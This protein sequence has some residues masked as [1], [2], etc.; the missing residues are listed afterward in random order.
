MS[1]ELKYPHLLQPLR[2][3]GTYF[4]NR[5]FSAPQG[6][7]N[8]CA[9]RHPTAET[10]AF[11]E[12][13]AMGGFASVCVGDCVVDITTGANL[14]FLLDMQDKENLPRMAMLAHAITRHGAVASAELAH[15]GLYSWASRDRFGTK[16]YGPV[17]CDSRYG[18]IE[19][20]SEEMIWDIIGKYA[21]AAEFAKHCGFNMITIHA[22]HGWLP[23]Q[24]MAP[25]MNTRTDKWG[26]CFENRMRLPIE[27]AKA[28]RKAVGEDMPIEFRFSG[29]EVVK[30]GF[31]LDEGVKIA[32]AMDGYVDIIHVSAGTHEVPRSW[33]VV[34]PSMFS[35]DG[36]NS[37]FAREIK[38]HVK[39]SLVSTVGAFTDPQ[40]MEDF[41]A[42]GGADIINVARQSLA[43]PDFP[44]KVRAGRE[45]EIAKCI[46]CNKCFMNSGQKRTVRCSLN[47]EVG[48]ELDAK[49]QPPVLE[50][51]RVM[52]AGGGVGGMEAAIQCAKRGHD[53]VL[54]EKS[55]SLG[56]V[57][58][59]EAKVPFKKNL[60]HY[61]RR[62]IK[63]MEKYG[64]E[65]RF[66]TEVTPEYV[67][68]EA[69]DVLI[70]ALGAVAITPPIPGIELAKPAEEV[71]INPELAQGKV[72][73][74]GAGLVGLELGIWLAQT[75][76]EV[77]IVEMRDRAGID[78]EDY[79]YLCYK[80]EIE[81][82]NIKLSL[83]TRAVAVEADGLVVEHEGAQ[84]K[85]SADCI[86]CAAGYKPLS[87]ECDALNF[88]VPEFY[89][90]G[91][92]MKPDSI[93]SATKLAY[94]AAMNV[95]RV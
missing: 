16:L 56:G 77:E 4:R 87:D 31:G 59:C 50:K 54:C 55:D 61:L 57:L 76:R 73:I 6:N 82:H 93:M 58:K 44:I 1:Y 74:L 53:V 41:L 83:N 30:E 47:P 12:R 63:L 68:A 33:P 43:D 64:V 29:S 80:F 8:V 65:V 23:A 11:Y 32:Q 3:R 45:D 42:S 40:H 13:K 92:C 38:K 10:I 90:I 25:M 48:M 79:P 9:D 17:E 22:G 78:L 35:P 81:D 36:V 34:H 15:D 88:T 28:V 62:Q 14:P 37:V 24:F 89:P 21:S 69:P 86:I 19:Q 2:I 49:M 60:D 70:A 51:K 85:I 66:N 94:S 7:Y 95:G 75:G 27:I 91:D 39:K 67:N 71:Y 18:H 72:V 5:I 84:R 26:G 20:M 46:R 52:V